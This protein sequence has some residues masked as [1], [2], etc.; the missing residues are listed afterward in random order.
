MSF[1]VNEDNNGSN[2]KYLFRVHFITM[3]IN[4][5]QVYSGMKK[6]FLDKSLNVGVW[7]EG[8]GFYLA[9]EVMVILDPL[10]IEISIRS[11]F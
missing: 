5:L 9:Q 2:F 7:N 3:L 11:F 8:K 1:E 6:K 10:S 4:R